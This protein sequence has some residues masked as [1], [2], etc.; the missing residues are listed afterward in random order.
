MSIFSYFYKSAL[1][2]GMC[3]VFSSVALAQYPSKPITLI[4]NY[5]AGGALD[6]AARAIASHLSN[7]F[8]KTIVVE[9]KPGASGLIG[10]EFA[11]RQK[12]D[13]YTM[14]ATID[15]LVTVNPYIFGEKRFDPDEKL[16]LLGLLGTFNQVLLVPKDSAI[17]DMAALVKLSKTK[18]LNYSSAGA[19]T[20]GHLAMESL[21]LAAHINIMNI[22]FNGNAPALNAL[23]GK[24]VDAGFLA[25]GGSTLQHVKAGSLIPLAVSGK[26]RDLNL[27]EVPTVAE[28][29]L[30]GLKDFDMEFAFFLMAPKGIDRDI[31]EKWNAAIAN[32]MQS[33]QIKSQFDN[34]N[35]HRIKG[36]RQEAKQWL[37][38]YGRRIHDTIKKAKITVE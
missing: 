35:I 7:Q 10:A 14:L 30:N 26:M 6:L 23:L 29:S 21:K 25:L 8:G 12:P 31:A 32:A 20:P 13:G 5:P 9:N 36:S 16:E 18:E 33:D 3:V 38:T 4:V 27:P 19:G 24:Q 28:S 22:P 17:T 2:V 37:S 1:I 15:S 11:S 34:L